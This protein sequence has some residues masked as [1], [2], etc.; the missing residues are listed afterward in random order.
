M[1]EDGEMQMREEEKKK[2][3]LG[4]EK[5]KACFFFFIRLAHLTS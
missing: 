2:W 4:I 5:N 1:A 3:Q